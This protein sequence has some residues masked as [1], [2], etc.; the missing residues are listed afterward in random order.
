[1][2]GGFAIIEAKTKTEAIQL[3]KD[4]LK[5]AGADGVC[6]LRQLYEGPPQTTR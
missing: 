4:F 6:E 1:M 2:I 5:V 3:T